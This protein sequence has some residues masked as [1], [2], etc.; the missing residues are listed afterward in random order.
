[1]VLGI[2]NI[3]SIQKGTLYKNVNNFIQNLKKK[4]KRTHTQYTL[5]LCA[6]KNIPLYVKEKY[7]RKLSRKRKHTQHICSIES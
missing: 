2:Y 5:C 7:P 6:Y 1:M 3:C 4:K